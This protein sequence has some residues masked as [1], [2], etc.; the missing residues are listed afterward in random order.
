MVHRTGLLVE[1]AGLPACPRRRYLVAFLTAVNQFRAL[2]G[3]RGLTPV[4]VFLRY[5]SFRRNPSIFHLYYSDRFALAVAWTGTVLSAALL[6]GI[7]DHVPLA[8][9]MVMWAALWALYLSIVNVG[10]VWY[11]FGWE[12][13]L[14]E[15]GF[16][17]TFLGNAG[18]APPAPILWL[19]RWLL[20]RLEF[21]AGLIKLRG[22]PCWRDLTCL[23]YHHETQPMPSPLS[24]LFHRLPRPLHRI[25]VAGN[26]LAQLVMPFAFFAPQPVASIGAGYII[27]TQGRAAACINVLTVMTRT[28]KRNPSGLHRRHPQD[29]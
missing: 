14:L 7:L 26:H 5:T 2:L 19:L 15:T 24:W 22:D 12:S 17:A 25:E 16:L 23:Y 9:S 8:V 29:Q 20:F 4:P 11:A 13:L 27:A 18:T 10:Q 28:N 21:G 3:E 6:A 1:Q